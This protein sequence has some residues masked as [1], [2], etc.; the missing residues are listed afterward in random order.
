MVVEL[1]LTAEANVGQVQV[2][3]SS[4]PLDHSAKKQGDA[5][6][7]SQSTQ[8]ERANAGCAHADSCRG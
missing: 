8:K 6:W 7:L 4:P 1:V 5:E 2:P 3:E